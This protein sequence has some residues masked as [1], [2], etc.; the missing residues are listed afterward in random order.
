MLAGCSGEPGAPPLAPAPRAL[1]EGEGEGPGRPAWR[2]PWRSVSFHLRHLGGTVPSVL[3]AACCAVMSCAFWWVPAHARQR[4][5][6][7][8]SLLT[9]DTSLPL[10][11]TQLSRSWRVVEPGLEYGLTPEA[12]P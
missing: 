9:Q 12:L 5:F 6:P 7:Y 10:V 3:A 8:S 2:G 4:S 11:Q 1:R